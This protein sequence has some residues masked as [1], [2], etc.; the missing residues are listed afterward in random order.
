[1]DPHVSII[2]SGWNVIRLALTSHGIEIRLSN[3][4]RTMHLGFTVWPSGF[5][6]A[7]WRLPESVD[8]GYSNPAF[9]RQ[10]AETAERGKF[11][12]FFIGDQLVAR[13]DLQHQ[14]PNHVL[15]PEALTLAGFIAASTSHIG[16]VA[17]VNVTYADPFSVAR[18]T[19]T[20]DHLSGG[21][22]AWNV[23]TGELDE[24]AANFNRKSHWDNSRRYDSA[25]EFVEVVKKLWD[26]WEDG[27]RIADKETGDFIDAAK[28]HKIDHA[29]EFFSVAGPLNV[30]RPVQG[31]IP[32]VNAGRSER[33]LEFG[34]K[35][36]D[37]KFTNSTALDLPDAKAYY[38]D[39]KRRLAAF[40][41]TPDQ[42]L[43]IPG[44]VVYTGETTEQA[45]E[46]YSRIH[47]RS[48]API[49]LGGLGNALGVEL[50]GFDTDTPV[51]RVEALHH[52]T[53]E[54]R[55]VLDDAVWQY[56]GDDI[57]LAQL[58]LSF[59]R[60]WNFREVVGNPQHV[61]DVL[62][63]WFLGHAADGFMIFPPHLPGALDDFV[64]L[65][66]PELQRRGLYRTEY[67]ETTLRERFG[68]ARPASA[69]E[70]SV[71]P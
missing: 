60:R 26:S 57:T 51:S 12:F 69:F 42:Q 36:S 50:T 54:A 45:Q 7:G 17:T 58:Y 33:S 32:L 44:I 59:H 56:G 68:L 15:R 61:A 25:E 18:A 8:D 10:L 66:V 35:Y 31:Q 13:P 11:D 14:R 63:E 46:L 23:V 20:L 38:D 47:D 16:I 67:Q 28:V 30:E 39:T 43:V 29:G 21:R 55:Q 4:E 64:D 62:E 2:V 9:L 41:R 3:H 1:M 37:M 34:A 27:A 53:S 49:D 24:A 22:I 5:H 6:P 65:V 40:G 48:L 19:A 70:S 52:L 71:T